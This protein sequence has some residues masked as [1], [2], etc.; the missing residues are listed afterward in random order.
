M[1]IRVEWKNDLYPK[2][3][4][5]LNSNI[6]KRKKWVKKEGAKMRTWQ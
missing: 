2:D 3:Y 4:K 6:F 5:N 1:I